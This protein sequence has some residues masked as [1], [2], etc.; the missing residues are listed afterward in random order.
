MREQSC[1]L[2]RLRPAVSAYPVLGTWVDRLGLQAH[3]QD[4]RT[5]SPRNPGHS[6]ES[7]HRMYTLNTRSLWAVEVTQFAPELKIFRIL[8][9]VKFC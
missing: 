3:R 5:P 4:A 6:L 7:V 1:R 8:I 2:L 9:G